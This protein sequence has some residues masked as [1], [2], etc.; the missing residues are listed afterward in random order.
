ML[1]FNCTD[2]YKKRFLSGYWRQQNSNR[3]E[4]RSTW[5]T[6]RQWD[7]SHGKLWFDAGGHFAKIGECLSGQGSGGE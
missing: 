4:W 5:F 3:M 2:Y 7:E 6:R 1:L